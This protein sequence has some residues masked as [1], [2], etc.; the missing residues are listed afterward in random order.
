MGEGSTNKA[1]QVAT[2]SWKRQ[3]KELTSKRE[4]ICQHL[5]F[6]LLRPILTSDLQN[7]EII[8][9]CFFKPLSMW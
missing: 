7:C 9:V 3:G 5:D 1:I 8:N 2:N 4:H 6:S